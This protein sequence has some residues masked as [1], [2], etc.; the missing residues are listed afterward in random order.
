MITDKSSYSLQH[1]NKLHIAFIIPDMVLGG[2]EKSLL[3]LLDAMQGKGFHITLLL[4]RRQGELLPYVP[5]W[6]DIREIETVGKLETIRRTISAA[7][8][9]LGS[10]KLFLVA[11]SIYHK[12]GSKIIKK[13]VNIPE[14]VYDVAIA[15]KDGAATWYTAQS[16]IAPVKIAFIHTD[17]KTAGYNP[18]SQKKVYNNFAKIFC[19]SK[20]SKDSFL[21]V[22]PE[23]SDRTE[24]FY[25]I[26][27]P[28]TIY[29]LAKSGT[30]YNDNFSGLRILTIGRLSHEKGIDK[31]I[32][33]ASRLK[34]KNYSIRW[35]VIGDG[36][37]KNKLM[38]KAKKLH[39]ENEV[40]FLGSVI[41]PYRFLADCDIYVQPSNY[42]GYCIS[43]AEARLFCKPIVTCDFCG[44]REQI[45]DGITGIIT[46]ISVNELFAGVE[47]LVID[48]TLRLKFRYNLLH[49]SCVFGADINGFCDYLG[50]LKR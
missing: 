13:I 34:T 1:Q 16:S 42:E 11:K 40:I 22:L 35:Y 41:N 7:L 3:A 47:K 50:S 38:K 26:V 21:R 12:Y 49:S 37:D 5:D 43:L 29:N 4:F 36:P 9:R 44:A 10:K 18:L 19:N 15:Y 28:S 8:S 24:V 46:G 20:E 31:V 17:F 23:F 27:N 2:V 25:N 32:E 6:V 33:V 48:E 14:T 30:S 39:V 45:V